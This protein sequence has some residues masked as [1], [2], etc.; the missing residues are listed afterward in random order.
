MPAGSATDSGLTSYWWREWREFFLSQS[1]I[2][3]NRNPVLKTALLDRKPARNDNHCLV[4]S[5]VFNSRSLFVRD[6][7]L[8]FEGKGWGLSNF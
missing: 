5:G 1:M 3:K 7:P 8:F 2:V 4:D 6:G